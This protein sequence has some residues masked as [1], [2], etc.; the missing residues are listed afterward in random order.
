MTRSRLRALTAIC[1]ICTSAVTFP[2]AA[3]AQVGRF[4][5]LGAGV[6]LPLGESA[7]AMNSG[8][9][10]QTM[11]GITLP[12][13]IIN[14]RVGGTHGQSQVKSMDGGTTTSTSVMAGVMLTPISIGVFAPYALADAGVLHARYR[15]S[16]TSFAWQSG[17]GLLVQTGTVGWFVEGRFMQARRSGKRAEMIPVAVGVRL[18]W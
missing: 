10:I 15:G 17:V 4:L 9:L 3:A 7:D 16:A 13:G 2:R 5:N 14:L 1:F 6:S 11:G 18:M 8:W 12:G